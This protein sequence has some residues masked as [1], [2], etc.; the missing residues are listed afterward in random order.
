M[1]PINHQPVAGS[2][3]MKKII[4]VLLFAL[5]S[6]CVAKEVSLECEGVMHYLPWGA[7][8]WI[9]YKHSF[10]IYFDE[11]KNR[12]SWTGI[13][14]CNS[15]FTK[16]EFKI[17][18]DL[19]SYKCDAIEKDESTIPDKVNGWFALSRNTGKISWGGFMTSK[20]NKDESFTQ[21]GEALCSLTS[22]K[23]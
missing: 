12:L 22:K 4:F 13:N 21:S 3:D 9:S 14:W 7:K 10:E 20:K 17:T 23:F 19:I 18:K 2:N 1:F 16:D 5:P 11:S 15:E 6:F 8:E